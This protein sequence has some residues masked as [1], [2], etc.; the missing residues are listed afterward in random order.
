MILATNVINKNNIVVFDKTVIGE[1]CA[2]YI[3][4]AEQKDFASN[5]AN[6]CVRHADKDSVPTSLFQ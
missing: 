6:V 2:P 5:N 1:D 4:I 3:M